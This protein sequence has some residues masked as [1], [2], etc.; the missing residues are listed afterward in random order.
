MVVEADLEAGRGEGG[1]EQEVR[2]GSHEGGEVVGGV[3][4]GVDVAGEAMAALV[5]PAE[6]EFEAVAPAAALE[7][8]V[9]EVPA[10]FFFFF[11]FFS[12]AVLAVVIVV[13]VRV[14]VGVV[15]V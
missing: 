15:P 5:D 9:G 14:G 8:R 4:A 6:G 2:V 12:V 7:G 13:G 11:F 3:V 10:D 1:D